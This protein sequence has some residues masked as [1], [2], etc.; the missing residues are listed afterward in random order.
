MFSVKKKFACRCHRKYNKK[1]KGERE[2]MRKQSQQ[3][4][5]TYGLNLIP[6]TTA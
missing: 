6:T 1:N 5:I 4:T 3:K 2:M